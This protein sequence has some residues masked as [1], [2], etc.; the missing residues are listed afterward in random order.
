MQRRDFI[1]L[2]GGA[3]IAW[4]LA[5][6]AQQTTKVRMQ[7]DAFGLDPDFRHRGPH[8]CARNDS[9]ADHSFTISAHS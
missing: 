5:A 7:M 9:A 6:R 1:S 3:A 2:C 8:R 4:P